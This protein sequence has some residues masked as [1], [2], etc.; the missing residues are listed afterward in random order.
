LGREIFI[1]RRRKKG[2]GSKQGMVM[3]WT[4]K[5][6]AKAMWEKRRKEAKI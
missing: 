6:D 2:K 3:G 1:N 4:N 5:S